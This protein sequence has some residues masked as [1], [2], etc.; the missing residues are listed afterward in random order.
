MTSALARLSVSLVS[1]FPRQ[2][3][4]TTSKGTTSATTIAAILI[5]CLVP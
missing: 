5:I 3:M 4:I 2:R 1:L